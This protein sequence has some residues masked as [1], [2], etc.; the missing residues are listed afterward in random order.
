VTGYGQ[1]V[2]RKLRFGL[3]LAVV[4][5]AVP[6][7]AVRISGYSRRHLCDPIY[8]PFG[9]VTDI[10]YVHKPNLSRARARGLAV[11]N[12]DSIG[13]RSVTVGG[14]AGP[15]RAGEYRIA[16]VGNSVTF[17]EGVIK[18]ED[19]FVQVLEE[20]LN[21]K[22]TAFR[23]RLFN[24]GAS[25]YSVKVMTAT[26]KH[27]MLEVEPD[28]VVMA[29]VP[30]DFDLSRTPSVD[31][32]GYLTDNKLSGFLPRESFVRRLLRKVHLVY[33]LREAIYPYFDKER[34]AED[35]FAA[36]ALPS[37]YAYVR[38]FKAAAE[39]RK[40]AYRIV[41]LPSLRSRFGS[42][43]ERLES[44]AIA[45]V[46]LTSLRDRFTA[47][48]FRA[49]RFDTHPSALVHREIGQSIAENIL[50]TQLLKGRH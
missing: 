42:L 40:L 29:L 5:F 13:L 22:Q 45:F 32:R 2:F 14:L 23:A 7:L 3:Y 47:Q 12:T 44:D 46:D 41:L 10:P 38:E 49:S 15:R 48:Q 35:F 8:Q 30:S 25:A 18:T 31:A 19:T 17:G 37:S 26:L 11:I 50:A 4:V 1:T 39:E 34:K 21:R 27:R 43:T 6:E 33:L 36:G 24:F 20:T 16:V 28:L 9:A